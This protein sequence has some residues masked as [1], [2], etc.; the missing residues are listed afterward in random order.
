M[1]KGGPALVADAGDFQPILALCALGLGADEIAA[2]QRS[3]GAHNLPLVDYV[4]ACL[5][6]GKRSPAQA[7]D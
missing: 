3:A 7:H 4:R 6:G 1:P 2:L 5:V